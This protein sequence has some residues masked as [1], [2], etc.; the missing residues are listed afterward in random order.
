MFEFLAKHIVYPDSALNNGIKGK[1]Y[2]SFTVDS[3]G[4]V[5]DAEI[6]RGIGYGCDEQTLKAV[7]KMPKWKPAIVNGNAASVRIHLPITF[8]LH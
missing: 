4:I 8:K 7:M 3:A 1:V 2:V 5:R 6:A